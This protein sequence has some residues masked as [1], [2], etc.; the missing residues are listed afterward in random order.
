MSDNRRVRKK[1]DHRKRISEQ[2]PLMRQA[3]LFFLKL[4]P[5]MFVLCILS[6]A[7]LWGYEYVITADYF[8]AE[9]IEIIG[10]RKLSPKDL[11]KYAGLEKGINL[12]SL[13]LSLV[14]KRLLNSPWVAE[15]EVRRILPSG[16]HI[17]IKEHEPLAILDIGRKFIINTDG[18]VFK[19][20]SPSDPK[21]LPLVTGLDFSEVGLSGEPSGKLFQSVMEILVMGSTPDSL[22]QNLSIKRIHADHELGISL[23]LSEKVR[24]IRLGYG[25]YGDKYEKLKKIFNYMKEKQD[26][27]TVDAID[28]NDMG[29]III[30]PVKTESLTGES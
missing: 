6:V 14:Q 8:N 23:Y 28:I 26:V 15:A 12:L 22:I 4:M 18:A 16:I 2:L 21:W 25:N 3:A 5:D 13:N 17:T 19:E 9:D 11:L 20:W 30:N 27:L 1:H 7:L 24:E 10:I 29:R